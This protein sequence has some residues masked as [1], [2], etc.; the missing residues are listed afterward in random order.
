MDF[1][2]KGRMFR[3]MWLCTDDA[4]GDF[5]KEHLTKENRSII[6]C[7]DNKNNITR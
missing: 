5:Y 2:V 3:S 7:R 1:E 4:L 6:D